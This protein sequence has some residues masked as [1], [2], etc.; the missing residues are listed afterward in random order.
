[1]DFSLPCAL[2]LPRRTRRKPRLGRRPEFDSLEV[3]DLLA[4]PA[5]G[6]PSVDP[7]DFRVTT[8]AS[9]LNYPYSMQQLSDG[10]LLVATSRPINPSSPSYWNS[11]GELVRLVDADGNGEAD[12]PGTVLA[13]GLPGSLTSVRVAGNL[14]FATSSQEGSQRI[15]VLRAGATPADPLTPVGSIDFDFPAGWWHTTYALAVRPTPGAAG[16][17][18]LFFNVGSQYNFEPTTHDRPGQRPD[19]GR[20][21]R[22]LDLHGHRRPRPRDARPVEPDADRHWPAQ[23]RGDR[24]PPDDRRPVLRGQRHRRL[25]RRQR[26][27]QRRRAEPDR[28][29]PT[30]AG[31]SRISAT[32][33]IT[34]S[35]ARAAR[36]G[37]GGID[38]LFAFQPIPDPP[39]AP[40]AK[41]RPRSPWPRRGSRAVSTTASSSASTARAATGGLA[42]E[43]NPL[44][45]ANL[46]TGGY[47]HFISNNE[48]SVGH[49]DGLLSTSDSLFVADID[50]T[51]RLSRHAGA[52]VIYQIRAIPDI[53]ALRLRHDQLTSGAGLHARHRDEPLHRGPGF[54]WTI[55]CPSRDRGSGTALT[56]DFA[57]TEACRWASGSTCPTASTT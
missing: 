20:P 23:R 22:R 39:T 6:G 40:R 44:V 2:R 48:P 3:R 25:R 12:G 31:P 14:V 56:R 38:P 1:M 50:P 37:S 57:M 36:W 26:A 51:G 53:S 46:A 13:T 35:T 29:S 21:Q 18:D 10:S 15:T 5:V 41:A 32:R 52:G 42:N 11:T 24:R 30:S 16:R 17:Y 19:H 54:G 4:A 33:P 27:D 45:F 55:G 8:F 9:G 49:L 43:E 7:A 47:F 28:R 34:S